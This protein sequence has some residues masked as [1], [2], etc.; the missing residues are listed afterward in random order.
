MK[1]L[2]VIR[3]T[4]EHRMCHNLKALMQYQVNQ[5]SKFLNINNI[6]ELGDKQSKSYDLIRD[7]SEDWRM[8]YCGGIC[9]F[10]LVCKDNKWLPR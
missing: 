2:I 9:P 7:N 10:K 5:I 8:A 1:P 3:Q 6:T 4:E